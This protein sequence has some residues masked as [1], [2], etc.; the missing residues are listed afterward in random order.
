MNTTTLS[1]NKKL[2]LTAAFTALVIV[3][4][5]TPLGF[6]NTAVVSITF[7]QIPVILAFLLV[8]LGSGVFTGTAFGIV[9]IIRAS[10]N[11]G[12]IDVLF[13]NPLCSVLPR[14][15]FVFAG[16]GLWKLLNIIPKMPK[17]LSVGI[18]SFFATIAHTA[19]VLSS[20]YLIYAK[21]IMET[22]KITNF[23]G[24]L[25]LFSFNAFF[26]ALA[27]TIICTLVFSG[28]YISQNRKSKLSRQ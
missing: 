28:I 22:F 23:V 20:L 17:V 25:S 12:P 6:L 11:P 5:F 2:A 3:L 10:L 7:L 4:G 21:K 15:L 26:E 19:L 27:S 1:K 14:V 8:G 18:T 9:S 24:F 13:F 16:W